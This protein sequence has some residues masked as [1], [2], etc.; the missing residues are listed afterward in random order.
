[1]WDQSAT[2]FLSGFLILIFLIVKEKVHEGFGKSKNIFRRHNIA[3]IYKILFLNTIK[4]NIVLLILLKNNFQNNENQK[5]LSKSNFTKQFNTNYLFP[6][7]YTSV[8]KRFINIS[9]IYV[10]VLSKKY[11]PLLRNFFFQKKNSHKIIFLF[12]IPEFTVP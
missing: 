1:M 12:R 8:K 2:V 7:N 5:N 10:I 11:F 4:F 9:D 3:Q 6:H